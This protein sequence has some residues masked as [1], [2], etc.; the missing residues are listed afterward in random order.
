MF[1]NPPTSEIIQ[2]ARPTIEALKKLIP[3]WEWKPKMGEWV[4]APGLTLQVIADVNRSL[5][6]WLGCNSWVFS[7]KVTPILDW[8]LIEELLDNA[9][10]SIDITQCETVNFLV[11]LST[12]TGDH[13]VST[14][15]WVS[16]QQA[17]MQAIVE[18][19]SVILSSR[20]NKGG[21]DDDIR[22]NRMGTGSSN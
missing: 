1:P 18:L 16:R 11:S 22:E 13:N 20:K 14:D 17:V 15:S 9:G 5:I 6:Y 3:G 4:I 8:Q 21:A 7:N 12:P 2:L 10:Y 19:A